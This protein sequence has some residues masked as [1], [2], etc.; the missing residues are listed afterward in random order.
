MDRDA[1]YEQ[2]PEAYAVALRLREA[3]L[4]DR[5]VALTLGLPPEAMASLLELADA[6]LKSLLDQEEP[7]GG[8]P[9]A[10]GGGRG[11]VGR[12]ARRRSPRAE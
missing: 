9:P 7:T 3:G 5:A 11:E 4:D 1:A 12:G 2:L 8:E 6:K 10:Q